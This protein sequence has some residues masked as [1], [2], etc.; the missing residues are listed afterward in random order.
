MFSIRRDGRSIANLEISDHEG[1]PGHP[2]ISQLRGPHNRKAPLDVWQA[3]FA[4]L[5]AQPFRL[6]EPRMQIKVGKATRV[7]RSIKLWQPFVDV[8][9]SDT[10]ELLL[11]YL[12]GQPRPV[13]T[14]GTDTTT[15]R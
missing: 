2:T 14:S 13:V 11:R 10:A 6:A 3:T 5:G 1:E 9:P 8:L 7:R 15:H 12:S 4:W